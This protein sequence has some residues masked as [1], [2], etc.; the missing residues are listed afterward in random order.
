[1]SLPPLTIH[2]DDEK[3]LALADADGCGLELR[4]ELALALD[5]TAACIT[6]RRLYI[7]HTRPGDSG[8]T[9]HEV[10]RPE[11]MALLIALL[12]PVIGPIHSA[13]I[14][15]HDSDPNTADTRH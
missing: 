3:V 8:L 12:L 9:C 11:D 1:M 6:D 14:Q 10:E 2:T 15:P 7:A 13:K 4:R 5:R